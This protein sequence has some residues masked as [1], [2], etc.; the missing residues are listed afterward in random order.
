MLDKTWLHIIDNI[1]FAFQPIVDINTGKTLAYEA[2]LRNYKEVGFDSIDSFF[3]TAYEEKILH[4]L[5]IKLRKKVLKK[6]I[7][8]K[9]YDKDLKIFYNLDNRIIEMP[10]YKEGQTSKILDKL[11]IDKNILTFEISEKH[12]FRS[13]IEAQTVFNLYQEQGYQ[14]A[15]D[16]FGTGFSG[17]KLLYYLNPNHIK[18]D[19]FFITDIFKDKK[20]KLFLKNIIN[21]AKSINSTVIAEG[22]ET[23]E[24]LEMCQEIGC[25]SVQGYYIQRPTTNVDELKK[26]YPIIDSIG[27]KINP[28]VKDLSSSSIKNES[29][30]HFSQLLNDYLIL[31]TADLKGTIRTVSNAFC[32]ISQYNKEELVG[33]NHNIVK[34][35][36]TPKSKIIDIWKTIEAGDIWTGEIQN[37]SK[38]GSSYWL[39]KVISPSYDVSGNIDGYMAISHDIT[40]K[41]KLE[42]ITIFDHLTKLNNKTYFQK[43]L[44]KKMNHSK[45]NNNHITLILFEID[46]FKKYNKSNSYQQGDKVLKKVAD[47]I[48]SII[49]EENST[50]RIGGKEFAVLL[51]DKNKKTSI[52]TAISILE[53]IISLKIKYIFNEEKKQI[54]LSA[55]LV[56]LKGNQIDEN[57][58]LL[59]SAD[60]SLCK[61]KAHGSNHIEVSTFTYTKLNQK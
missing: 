32:E 22:I 18:I 9:L 60:I 12:K 21:I 14:I 15:L 19:R 46:D 55:G 26:Y 10:N 36:N 27:K 49:E 35:P 48:S 58:N 23:K 4:T 6:I 34:H 61:A 7:N 17:L 44:I 8:S 43:T 40:E 5:D 2:L 45:Q 54:T 53:A 20:K 50:F 3:D 42:K 16:D 28:S 24:E 51:E 57:T 39:K 33:Q 47:K 30:D 56:C 1:D 59:I 13:F 38:E 52:N 37:L 11:N 29:Q 41:K 25:N 31:S